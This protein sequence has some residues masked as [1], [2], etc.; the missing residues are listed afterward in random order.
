MNSAAQ[1]IPTAQPSPLDQAKMALM[2][3]LQERIK[4]EASP[5]MPPN[6]RFSAD[7][8]ETFSCALAELLIRKGLI[9][10]P[11]MDEAHMAQ[12]ENLTNVV[13]QSTVD[14]RAAAPRIALANASQLPPG[15]G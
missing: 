10:R 4:V 11:E 7:I 14:I 2:H 15:R 9:T 12:L 1:E 13:K 6:L 8:N 3:A 5:L